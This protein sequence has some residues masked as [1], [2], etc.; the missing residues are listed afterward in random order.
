MKKRTVFTFLKEDCPLFSRAL[1]APWRLCFLAAGLVLLCVG[2]HVTPSD[3]WDYPVSFIMGVC[4]YVFA[5]WTVRALVYHRWKWLAGAFLL[6]WVSIDGVYSL[7]WWSRGFD[8]L[9]IFRGANAIYCL[10]LYFAL[11]F[12]MNVEMYCG[13]EVTST[14]GLA[15]SCFTWLQKHALH[16]VIT[17]F[18]MLLFVCGIL[19]VAFSNLGCCGPSEMWKEWGGRQ[20]RAKSVQGIVHVQIRE[21]GRIA[22]VCSDASVYHR[23][24]VEPVSSDELLLKSSDVGSRIVRKVEGEWVLEDVGSQYNSK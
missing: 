20:Y 23:F 24:C 9:Q 14:A 7:Y 1:I 11:G 19:L 17:C 18:L 3:D 6:M 16:A 15:H 8:A 21:F 4:A 5:P 2:S 13:D 22:D 12:V 10:P